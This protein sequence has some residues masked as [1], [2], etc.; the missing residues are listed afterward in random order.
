MGTQVSRSN[1]IDDHK[2][3]YVTCRPIG[4]YEDPDPQKLRLIKKQK[5]HLLMTIKMSKEYEICGHKETAKV[6]KT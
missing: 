4:R 1:F 3:C 2:Q 5:K 6:L